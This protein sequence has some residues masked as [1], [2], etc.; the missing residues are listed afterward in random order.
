MCS[1]GGG[2]CAPESLVP[3]QC[4]WHTVCACH[5]H[6]MCVSK[7]PNYIHVEKVDFEL[8][9]RTDGKPS[10]HILSCSYNFS[11]TDGKPSDHILSCSYNFLCKSCI[12][13]FRHRVDKFMQL[14]PIPQEEDKH[15]SSRTMNPEG[16]I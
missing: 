16:N 7:D 13:T 5:L 8:E 4:M 2:C 12:E 14:N 11:R 10:D 6:H 15:Y 9:S 1:Y 3:V